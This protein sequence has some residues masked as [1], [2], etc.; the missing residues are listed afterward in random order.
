MRGYRVAGL[1]ALG[2]LLAAC[3]GAA[4]RVAPA[5]LPTAKEAGE[6]D[7]P[8][9]QFPLAEPAYHAK[10]PRDLAPFAPALAALTEERRREL[11]GLL[12]ES[13]VAAIQATLA[14]GRITSADLVTW[15]LDRIARY[16]VNRLNAVME[17]NPQ[18]LAVAAE[19]D[20]E[21]AAAG[22]RGPLHGIPVLVKDNI[23]TAD[24]LHAAAGAWAL[25]DWQPGRDAFLVARLREAGAIIL[26]KTNMSE[27]A[28]YMDPCLPNGF[29]ALGGQ[30]Q[31]PYGP[32]D[33]SGSSSGSAVA[34]AADLAPLSVGSET[35]GS[36]IW[37]ARDHSLVGLKTSLGL[38]SRSGVVP[39]VDWMDV[40]GPFG[41]SVEDVAI[42]LS[43]LAAPGPQGADPDDPT[44]A[45]AAPLS[46]RDFT[47]YL[48]PE[49]AQR[50]RVGVIVVSPA[51]VS[52]ALAAQAAALGRPL[53]EA[54]A[55]DIGELQKAI[56][57]GEAI[58]AALRA[59]GV[60]VEVIP[61]ETA[62][63]LVAPDVMPVLEYGFRDSLD[64]FLDGW[65]AGA[66]VR[67]LAEVAAIN[68]ADPANRAPYGFRYV[69]GSAATSMS[70]EAYDALRERYVASARAAIRSLMAAHNVQVLAGHVDQSY[71]AAGF[72]A[73]AVPNGLDERGHPVGVVFVA[74]YLGEPQLLAAG[75][76]LER[77]RAGR[78]PPDL[79]AVL[80]TLPPR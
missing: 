48:T 39:L 26:G 62:L 35:Q 16:D 47:R 9:R 36:I 65:A 58:A 42:L 79:D 50:V 64:R 54:E 4:Q 27:W 45:S 14:G 11:D 24:G 53:S 51:S 30:T 72:P 80:A 6:D 78:V 67:S 34:V 19:M 13:S 70:A 1:A 55:A 59:Q 31:S 77:A 25:R 12:R 33:P 69:A 8:E 28:N 5:E 22:P 17:L 3:G 71:A 73:L 74:D 76:A 29:S 10:R 61:Y 20:A 7:C 66:P 43:A 38:V 2:L 41:R 21:R 15:Y 37:P 18:A 40:P 23:A 60:P 63:A 75:A 68:A 46:G 32:F 57:E 49:A 52:A 44:T 56:G